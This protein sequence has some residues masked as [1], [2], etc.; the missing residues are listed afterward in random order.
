LEFGPKASTPDGLV[1]QA[2]GQKIITY[3]SIISIMVQSWL[4]HAYVTKGQAT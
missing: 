3:I 2:T 4:A 1:I